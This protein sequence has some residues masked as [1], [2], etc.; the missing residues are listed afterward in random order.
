[1]FFKELACFILFSYQCSFAVLIN[2]VCVSFVRLTYLT[3]IVNNFFYFF[4]NLFS[5]L[6]NFNFRKDFEAEKEGFEPSRRY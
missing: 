1:M 2:F 3:N 6:K 4:Q 5:R